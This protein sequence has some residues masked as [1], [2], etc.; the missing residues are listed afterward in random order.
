M[1]TPTLSRNDD[2]FVLDFGDDEN[3]TSE[4]WVASIHE[5]LD[6]VAAAE[7]PRALV[8]TGSAKHYS[9]GLDVPYM[10]TLSPGDVADYVERVL[11]IPRRI[12]LLGVP[13]AAAVNGHA[14]GMGAFLV[15]AH[16]HAVMRADRGFVCFPEV[17]LGMPFTESLLDVA[18]AAL[19]PRTLR[20][21]LST[22]HRYGGADAV[23]AGIVDSTAP[24][25]ELTSTA[26]ALASSLASTAGPNLALIKRQ[27]LPTIAAR[28]T[29]PA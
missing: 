9:N 6:Q 21:A 25:D 8:T 19:A 5:L 20:Q 23:A 2:V 13:T 7:G 16:D 28:S 11:E 12:M 15:I 18:S 1:T 22:G 3:V 4:A 29:T 24:L 27:L 26:S 10:A 17:H 14:F